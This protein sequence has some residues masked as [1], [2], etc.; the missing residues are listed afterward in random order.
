MNKCG[1]GEVNALSAG[2]GAPTL[3]ASWN[4]SD[5]YSLED[6]VEVEK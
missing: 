5:A 2:L 6:A 3:A 1:I 4:R